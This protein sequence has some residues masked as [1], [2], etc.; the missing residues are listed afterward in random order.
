MT[1]M[2]LETCDEAAVQ[3][4]DRKHLARYTMGDAGLEREILA[5]F[6]GQAPMTIDRLR[7]ADSDKAWREAAHTLKGS[8]RAVGAWR[9]ATAAEVAEQ[10]LG[11][12]SGTAGRAA[13]SDVE[14][15][16]DEVAA[17]IAGLALNR[18]A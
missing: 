8:A 17:F 11:R 16:F 9:L 14:K 15:A 18:A 6:V 2:Q 13:I 3:P 5:L 1:I 12:Q 7:L 4:I 10:L